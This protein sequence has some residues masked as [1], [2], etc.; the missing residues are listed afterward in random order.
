MFSN[1]SLP[2]MYAWAPKDSTNVEVVNWN[3]TDHSDDRRLLKGS[4][5]A[6]L[7]AIQRSDRLS[8]LFAKETKGIAGKYTWIYNPISLYAATVQYYL[9][10]LCVLLFM[11]G[12]QP[13]RESKFFSMTWKN[14][15]RKPYTTEAALDHDLFRQSYD[16]CE[17]FCWHLPLLAR[18]QLG[19]VLQ[20]RS[21]TF[22]PFVWYDNCMGFLIGDVKG[23]R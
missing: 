3:F 19:R 18:S 20:A 7:S 2:R 5:T 12:G 9:K 4:E 6:L 17:V 11:S 10:R 13:I 21:K 1:A 14:T 8:K 22:V 16:T 15:Q 23:F